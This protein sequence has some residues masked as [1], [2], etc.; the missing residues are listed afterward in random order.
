MKRERDRNKI[1]ISM[2][3]AKKT[4]ITTEHKQENKHSRNIIVFFFF[5]ELTTKQRGEV[6]HSTPRAQARELSSNIRVSKI[7]LTRM[8]HNRSKDGGRWE[9]RDLGGLSSSLPQQHSVARATIDSSSGG[10]ETHTQLNSKYM[11]VW[12][13]YKGGRQTDRLDGRGGG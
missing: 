5:L 13:M 11:H 10:K 2:L 9:R 6:P 1:V 12:Y 8:T 3:R 7:K 4:T